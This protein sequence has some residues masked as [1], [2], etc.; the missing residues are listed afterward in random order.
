MPPCHFLTIPVRVRR[1]DGRGQ[2]RSTSA[3]RY[4]GYGPGFLHSTAI[5]RPVTREMTGP[6]SLLPIPWTD[7]LK[8]ASGTRQ[9]A[10][11]STG[12]G[13]TTQT[14]PRKPCPR[15][16]AGGRGS[17]TRL[18]VQLTGPATGVVGPSHSMNWPKPGR[19]SSLPS[20][21]RTWPRTRVIHGRPVISQP[22]NRL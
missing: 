20:L 4:V 17:G 22:S 15:F 3:T 18:P 9:P 19:C 8:N 5:A 16:S 7:G 10:H 1:F 14:A 12:T 11:P 13:R 2:G 21:S 6:A